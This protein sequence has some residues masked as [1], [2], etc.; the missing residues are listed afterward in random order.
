MA[1][2]KVIKSTDGKNLKLPAGDNPG[3]PQ[4]M[5][6]LPND[7]IL[8][9]HNVG[10]NNKTAKL[11]K[12]TKNGY[13]VSSERAI[14][15][16]GHCSGATYCNKNGM[17]YIACSHQTIAEIDGGSL[18][19]MRKFKIP[20]GT[21]NIAWDKTAQ[22]FYIGN[23]HDV[24]VH[25]Y[26]SIA[27][28]SLKQ[29]QRTGR[30][31]DTCDGVQDIGGHNGIIYR[32]KYKNI[33]MY[34]STNGKNLGEISIASY[35]ECES[36]A[37]D[38]AGRFVYLT[39]K[40]RGIHWTSWKPAYKAGTLSG[41]TGRGSTSNQ[42]KV[43]ANKAFVATAKK[44]MGTRETGNNDN[45]YGKWYGMN[46][47]PWCAIFVCW[48]AAHTF[49]DAWTK[50]FN[51]TALA[52]DVAAGVVKKGGKWIKQASKG[53]TTHVGIIASVDSG[54]TATTV[55]GNAGDKVSSRKIKVPSGT[56]T[57]DLIVFYGGSV[58][59]IARPKWP[60][61][62]F[63]V[64]GDETFYGEEGIIGGEAGPFAHPEQLYSSA[65]NYKYISEFEK[66]ES[67]EQKSRNEAIERIKKA[68]STDVNGSFKTTAPPD[69]IL[70]SIKSASN[71]KKPRT[72]V[73]GD[74]GGAYL[75]STVNYVEAPYAKITLGG[76]TFGTYSG[77]SYPN[78]IQG[79]DVK[80]TNGSMNEY[81]VTLIHQVAPGDNPNYIDNLIAANGF[82]IITI[83]YG[84]AQAGVAFRSVNALLIDVKSKYD[85]LNSCITYT[86]YA[87]SSS[88]M[89][90]L[91]RRNYPAVKD[92]P[93][94]IINKML[95][96]TGELLQYF[97]AMVNKTLVSS[98]NYIPNNDKEVELD[99]VENTT[100]LNYLNKLVSSMV[101]TTSGAI[102]DSIYYLDIN[103]EDSLGPYFTIQ[104][105]G[106]KLSTSSFPLVYEIDINYPDEESLAYNF[107]VNTDY[108]WPLA[109]QYNS[110]FSNYDYGI[111]TAGKT[112]KQA[113]NLGIKSVTG[114]TNSFIT[115][116]NWWTNVTEFPV[117]AT[118]ELK[119]LTSYVLL[120]NYIK[121]NVYYFGN[122][123]LSSGVYIVTGQEDILSGNG[124]RTRLD[125]LRV[126]G[127]N[128]HIN[129]DGRVV[130]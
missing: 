62:T 117:K 123:R 19:L 34:N 24:W 70:P 80:K 74:I 90:T 122:K 50:S 91:Q 55:E 63:V 37:F 14:S 36:V 11:R 49:G 99:A 33:I 6:I 13:V 56:T 60:D 75:P 44:E 51:K 108:T 111:T 115:D 94:N 5:A 128:Q 93:S 100:P 8:V 59:G 98:N 58:G 92:K 1:I 3:T 82:N 40:V 35:P 76:V 113:S 127:D 129:V 112:F 18:R 130:S 7:I 66:Q 101:S 84:D 12:Y 29:A 110:G 53:P 79:V 61:G 10:N 95:Y 54:G 106:T 119:G 67:E 21:S 48:C 25:T 38:S 52:Y 28:K 126:A 45:K 83:E 109:Y 2:V 23:T 47:Q 103:D 22:Q 105:V 20:H 121:V 17:I 30:K 39:A 57:G 15:G 87:T 97:P 41:T 32:I 42:Q 46:H 102:N 89:S 68:Y 26:N 107:S 120:L 16:L 31:I 9:V 81:T 64:N 86:L 4:S 96:E 88:V 104:E 118:L 73:K 124:F 125:L 85:F 69:I 43:T 65:N 27:N 71:Y 114:T 78:Y 116:K 77:G 72:K